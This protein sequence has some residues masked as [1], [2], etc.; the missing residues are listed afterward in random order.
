MAPA[1][2]AAAREKHMDVMVEIYL[3]KEAVKAEAKVAAVKGVHEAAMRAAN[4][5]VGRRDEKFRYIFCAC[6]T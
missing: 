5:E 6:D 2:I 3:R 1:E 4:L